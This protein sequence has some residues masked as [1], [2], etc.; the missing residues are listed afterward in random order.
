MQYIDLYVCDDYE[1]VTYTIYGKLQ[2]VK[3]PATVIIK[4]ER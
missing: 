3:I 4:K 1:V 2:Q